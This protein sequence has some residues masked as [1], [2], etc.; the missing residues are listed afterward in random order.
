[1]MRMQKVGMYSLFAFVGRRRVHVQSRSI[2][3]SYDQ[4]ITQF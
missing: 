4:T 3:Q 2:D 1:M